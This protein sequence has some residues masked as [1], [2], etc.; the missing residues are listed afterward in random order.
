MAVSPILGLDMPYD[1]QQNVITTITSFLLALEAN[2]APGGT[3]W[4]ASAYHN[5]NQSIANTTWTTLALNSEN[6]DTQ[7]MHDNSTN[8]SRI[9]IQRGGAYAGAG[10]VV[11]AASAAGAMRGGRAIVNGSTTAIVGAAQPPPVGGSFY[12]VVGFPILPRTYSAGDY[13]QLQAYQDS[14]GSL[15]AIADAVNG[16]FCELALYAL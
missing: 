1:G 2:A 11:F 9:T 6:A 12:A 10:R 16:Y 5:A 8:N 4:L 13:I 15:N 14:G 3:R 7:A